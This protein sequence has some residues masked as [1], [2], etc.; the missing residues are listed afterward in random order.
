MKGISKC[1][2][3]L[4]YEPTPLTFSPLSSFPFFSDLLLRMNVS[5][6]PGIF[7]ITRGMYMF[8]SQ[9]SYPSLAPK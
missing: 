1:V 8:L 2:Y 5:R 7:K 6:G 9:L 3:V 4:N